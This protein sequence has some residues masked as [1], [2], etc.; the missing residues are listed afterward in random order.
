MGE[1]LTY[2]NQFV[3][4]NDDQFI[5]GG[6]NTISVG[7]DDYGWNHSKPPNYGYDL[8]SWSRLSKPLR[9]TNTQYGMIE[10]G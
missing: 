6:N 4:N 8:S 3:Q 7:L 9:T 10:E 5:V 1:T 2:E